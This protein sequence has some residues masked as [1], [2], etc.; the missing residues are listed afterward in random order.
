VVS[1]EVETDSDDEAELDPDDELV[2]AESPT[3]RTP[4]P[5]SFPQ[6]AAM[7]QKTPIIPKNRID[8]LFTVPPEPTL[9]TSNDSR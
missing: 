4:T 3:D 1:W 2:L 7:R 8:N 5:S 9:E 6:P